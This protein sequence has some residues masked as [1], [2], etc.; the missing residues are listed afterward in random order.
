[1]SRPMGKE[2]S[3]IIFPIGLVLGIALSS[4]GLGWLAGAVLALVA[5]VWLFFGAIFL[6]WKMDEHPALQVLMYA[7]IILGLF[8]AV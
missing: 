3:W 2:S 4:G 5:L 6:I 8:W 7:A 1:M